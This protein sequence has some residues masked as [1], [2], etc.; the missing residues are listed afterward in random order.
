MEEEKTPI[1]VKILAVLVITFSIF[2]ILLNGFLAWVFSGPLFLSFTAIAIIVVV[3]LASG[4]VEL[5]SGIGLF[6]RK[7]WAW[8]WTLYSMLVALL[9][10]LALIINIALVGEI[11]GG[12]ATAALTATI[13]TV[14]LIGPILIHIFV[15]A[16]LL[17]DEIKSVF[18]KDQETST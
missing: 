13:A 18:V 11:I 2:M 17:T 9:M 15:I 7:K 6:R 10:F 16:F 12:L 1:A 3:L 14:L 8:S 5:I 4:I